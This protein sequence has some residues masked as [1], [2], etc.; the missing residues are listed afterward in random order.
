MER[1]VQTVCLIVI[2]TVLTGVALYWLR[3]VMVPFVLALF[4]T[5]GLRAGA[6]FLH[7]VLHVPQSAATSVTVVLG[8]VFMLGVG[9]AVSIS[10]TELREK[11]GLY[12]QHLRTLATEV[13]DHLPAH[14]RRES[15]E[16]LSNVSIKTVGSFLGRTASSILDALS[17]SFVVLIF[18]LFLMLG[19]G[20]RRQAQGMWGEAER[21]I[22][23]YIA[24]KATISL[25]T[26][27]LVGLTLTLLGVPLALVFGLLAFLLNFIPSVGSVLATLLPI[28]VLVVSP[29]VSFQNAVLAVTIPAILQIGIGNFVEPTIMG[30]SLDLHPASILL[31]LILWG[32]LWGVLGAILSVP[33]TVVVKILCERFEGSRPVAD[34]LA[35]RVEAFVAE[36]T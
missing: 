10:V 20:K 22:K 3:P 1:R 15:D 32:M 19:G 26:G 4:I 13:G 27:F 34:L 24:T 7:E 12:E 30:E 6:E 29:E 2:A 33:I 35:G 21:R 5:L 17:K 8:F 9:A 36:S 28:P 31:S 14:W 23:R 25:G 11:S 16:A 18:V